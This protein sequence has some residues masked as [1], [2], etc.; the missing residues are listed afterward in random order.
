MIRLISAWRGM[1][2]RV[3]V[4]L[5]VATVTI[6]LA[7]VFDGP[8]ARVAASRPL[9]YSFELYTMF[10][11]A[12]YLPL[13]AVVAVAFVL[14]D[15]RHGWRAAWFRGGLLFAAVT[16]SGVAAEILKML[17]RR[18][19]PDGD[20]VG[21]VFRPWERE[22]FATGGLGW[23]SSHT[24]VAFAAAWMLCRLHPR[25]TPLWI[26][27]GVAC[28]VSRLTGNAHFASDV[29]GGALLGYA[30]VALLWKATGGTAR[31]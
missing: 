18:E 20:L 4:F 31:A 3:L 21:H 11:L 28:G 26:L 2:P 14:V 5:V 10:R 30:V 1:V 27:I 16:I 25:G 8:I 9:E 15:S 7:L 17:I 19:R 29:V 13:W 6:G 12:G 23:P 22:V 24:A